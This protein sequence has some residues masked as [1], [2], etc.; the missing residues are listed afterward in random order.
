MTTT[1]K[2]TYAPKKDNN[3]GFYLNCLPAISPVN[4]LNDFDNTGKCT[5]VKVVHKQSKK[6]QCMKYDLNNVRRELFPKIREDQ[7]I[8][9]GICNAP[10]KQIIRRSD[11]IK[12][13]F[14][15]VRRLFPF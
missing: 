5:S 11:S 6:R 8:E 13:D 2:L 3:P 7:L 12:Y 14:N 15:S 10:K 4:L 1:N 9:N